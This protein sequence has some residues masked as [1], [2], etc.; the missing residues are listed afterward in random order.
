MTCSHIIECLRNEEGIEPES[1]ASS[2]W[3]SSYISSYAID[4]SSSNYFQSGHQNREQW[5]T[6]D[7]KKRV[8]IT[9]YLIGSGT[10]PSSGWI[11]NWTLAALNDDDSFKVLH[12][13]LQ[14]SDATRSYNFTKPIVTRYAIF[15]GNSLWSTDKSV[16]AFSYIKFF[17]SSHP[18]LLRNKYSCKSNRRINHNLMRIFFLIYY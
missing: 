2:E 1:I 14:S 7:F 18:H 6:V 11:Y 9:G 15:Y 17:G 3:G 10:T 5:W 4:Y 12:A 13:P 16:F 8:S